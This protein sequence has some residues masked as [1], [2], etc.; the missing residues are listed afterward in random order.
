MYNLD[1]ETM[2]QVMRAHRKTG[3]LHADLPTGVPGMAEPCRIEV[4]LEAGAVV[5]CFIIGNISGHRL[6]ESESAKRIARFGRLKWTFT[7]EENDTSLMIMSPLIPVEVPT[8]P[9][10]VVNLEQSQMQ[11]W[12][13]MHRKVFAL[14]DGTRSVTK[15]VGILSTSPDIVEQVLRDLQSIGVIVMESKGGTNYLRG[16]DSF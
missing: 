12:S 7:Q 16:G 9:R 13:R 1:F 6:S 2:K 5:S 10:R 3:Y 4:R 14:A 8:Y 11:T 15:I